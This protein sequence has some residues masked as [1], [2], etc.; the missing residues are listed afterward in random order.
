VILLDNY[1]K[2]EK[3]FG[4]LYNT[5][6]KYSNYI[7]LIVLILIVSIITYYRVMIQINIGPTEDTYSY[8]SNALVFAGQGMGYS[9]LTR[10]PVL[11]FLTSLLFRLGYVSP[12]AIFALDGA[13]FVF[14]VIGFYLLLKICFNGVES[15]LGALLFATFPVTLSFVGFGLTDVSSLSF[16]IWAIYFTVLAVKRNSKFFYL[17]FPFLMVAFLTRYAIAF[18]IF[19]MMLYILV[20]NG[21]VKDIKDILIGIFLSFLILISVLLFFYSTFGNPLYPFFSFYG[22]TATSSPISPENFSYNSDLFYFLF[23]MPIYV[24]IE[25][26][27]VFTVILLGIIV[28]GISNLKKVR[29]V[30]KRLLNTQNLEKCTKITSVTSLILL[31]IFIGT[32]GNVSYMLS[33]IIFLVLLF[34]LYELLKSFD[35]TDLDLHFLFFSWFMAFFIFQSVYLIKIDRYFLAMAP[36]LSYFLILGLSKVSDILNC[37]IR[38]KTLI[39][40]FFALTLIVLIL[41]SAA[42]YLPAFQKN[43]HEV[44]VAD[45]QM[46]SASQ[47]LLNY[48]PNYKN[49]TIYSDKWS[50][51]SWYLNMDVGKVPF[52]K[53]NQRFYNGVKNENINIKDNVAFN[54]YLESNN[55]DYYFCVRKGLN[56]THYEPIKQFGNVII[57]ERR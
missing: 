31:I 4:K 13:I 11:S 5:L 45:E 3:K 48:D 37:K 57:Y 19:P 55:V 27:A 52:F 26:T 34:G 35:I 32:L 17:A 28:F 2:S 14:G 20:N 7:S 22:A 40:N 43:M 46:N 29:S 24:G 12:T 15:F 33:E 47:W 53:D 25:S 23:R 41:F 21:L 16:S 50:A 9:D 30:C 56:L 6:K 8:L 36:P 49:R 51:F 39:S 44:K 18:A 1:D 10:P 54:S 42:A 38:N